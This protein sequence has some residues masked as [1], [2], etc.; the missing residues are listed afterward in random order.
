QMWYPLLLRLD[1]VGNIIP[2]LKQVPALDYKIYPNP[3]TDKVFVETP[4]E[5]EYELSFVNI[6]GQKVME[7]K[8]Q[9]P[10]DVNLDKLPKGL[11]IL[12]IKQNNR[13][14]HTQRLVHE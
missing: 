5:G 14:V 4:N 9:L 2:V 8:Q 6:L 7:F 10:A 3:F 12:E 11:Y 1:S 13:V